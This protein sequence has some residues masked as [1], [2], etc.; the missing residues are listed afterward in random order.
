MKEKSWHQ[1][2]SETAVHI[3]MNIALELIKAGIPGDTYVYK[4]GEHSYSV[5]KCKLISVFKWIVGQTEEFKVP[6]MVNF[7]HGVAPVIGL[8]FDQVLGATLSNKLYAIEQT[9]IEVPRFGFG[10]HNGPGSPYIILSNLT[11]S[12]GNQGEKLDGVTI[13]NIHGEAQAPEQVVLLEA[14]TG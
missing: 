13:I 8:C 2:E 10:W 9:G 5:Q 4:Y 12:L 3:V 1:I 6:I 14:I 11:R 7:R